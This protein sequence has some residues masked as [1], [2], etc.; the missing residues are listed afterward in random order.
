MH[1]ARVAARGLARLQRREQ[2]ERQVALGL[3]ER[4]DH[5]VDHRLARRGCCPGRCRT[6]RLVAGPR[7][8]LRARGGRVL[9]AARSSPRT[10]APAS[11]SRR[12]RIR[13]A[14][15]DQLDDLR[16]R[17]PS[18][19]KAS[20]LRAIADVDDRLRGGGAHARLGPEHAVADGEHTRL[21]RTADLAGGRVVA[22]DREGRD[23]RP[24]GFALSPAKGPVTATTARQRRRTG[25]LSWCR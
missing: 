24:R 25:A 19:N 4:V 13:V 14:L 15:Q 17:F 20:A 21:D 22:Q 5:P 12:T 3:L 1:A 10:G 23:R 11:A 7:R 2:S 6:C 18:R 16:G 8:R 9:A